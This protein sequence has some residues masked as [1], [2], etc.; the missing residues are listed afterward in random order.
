[1]MDNTT[2]PA[3]EEMKD[4][5]KE[6]ETV[7]GELGNGEHDNDNEDGFV[8]LLNDVDQHLPTADR[9]P[10]V[11]SGVKPQTK[12]LSSPDSPSNSLELQDHDGGPEDRPRQM[13]DTE[14]GSEL[15]LTQGLLFDI[16]ICDSGVRE[17][18]EEHVEEEGSES[19]RVK[20]S[21]MNRRSAKER[22][23][24][25]KRER[26]GESMPTA[27]TEGWEKMEKRER[28]SRSGRMRKMEEEEGMQD[29]GVLNEGSE[30]RKSTEQTRDKE[31][32]L[33]RIGDRMTDREDTGDR[34][35]DRGDIGD[36]D[37]SREDTG[38]REIDREDTGD[39]EIDREDTGDREI[40]REDTGDREMEGERSGDRKTE[41]GSVRDRE[42]DGEKE[43]AS[44]LSSEGSCSETHWSPSPHPILS[45]M[46]MHS[47]VSSSASSFNCS[48]AESDEVFSEGEDTASK[49]S[50]MR[51]C[52]SWRTFLTMMQWS[53]RRQSSWVQLAGHQGN[54][55]L[56][57]GGE[58]LKRFSEVE[59][60]CLQALMADPL[61]PFVP[62]YHGSVNRGGNSYIRLEDLLSG[63]KNPVIMDCKMGVRTYQEEELTKSHTKPTLRTDM[64]QK[65]VKVDP[66]ALTVEEHEQRGVT[67][68]RYLQWRDNT[69]ST[70]TL[71]FRIEGI[72]M[73][74]GSVQRDFKML[75]P[76]KVTEALLSFT[77]SHLHILKAYHSRL[78]ALDEALKES[79]FFKA[80]EVIGSSLLFVHDWTSKASIWMIDFGKTTPSP[81]TVQLSHDVP[82]AEGNREDGYLIGLA[83]L[84]SLVGQAISQAACR[85]EEKHGE[86]TDKCHTHPAGTG[87]HTD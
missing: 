6:K 15:H 51:R 70:S 58:V 80:H 41:G 13:G 46:L 85:Q 69:S 39:R 29:G 76:A 82:W 59:A 9:T 18:G 26:S 31:T 64:Y 21:R 75:T 60:V 27:K 57:E 48:S 4:V 81:S 37:I 78:Q 28:W 65:M 24:L 79:P 49:R 53:V 47:S 56:S 40:D 30:E 66:T 52:R 87:T 77:K 25:S 14:P 16:Q 55:Q 45:K 2:P 74:N 44:S 23:R 61:R 38:D 20:D 72:M 62:Q 1:M 86:E 42:K 7:E 22:W 43:G 54:F 32:E 67:K 12:L 5:E 73:E 3:L 35:T 34:E 10:S 71:G 68:W 36:R 11:F 63:L 50:T 19:E 33:E 84:T 17:R 83:A 8:G